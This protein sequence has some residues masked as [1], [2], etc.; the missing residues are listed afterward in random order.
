M[1]KCTR[2][3]RLA[4]AITDCSRICGCIIFISVRKEALHLLHIYSLLLWTL[5]MRTTIAMFHI[6]SCCCLASGTL[7]KT[8][9]KKS[10]K[11]DES[12]VRNLCCLSLNVYCRVHHSSVVCLTSVSSSSVFR[13]VHRRCLCWIE[14]LWCQTRTGKTL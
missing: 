2:R 9:A 7:S 4:D 1:S 10:H 5:K 6:A 12:D 8:D 14:V 11:V 13:H 3:F